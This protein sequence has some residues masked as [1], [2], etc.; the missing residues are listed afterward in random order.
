MSRKRLSLLLSALF[1]IVLITGYFLFYTKKDN[2]VDIFQAI[3]VD[4]SLIIETGNLKGLISALHEE[5]LIWKEL[6][7]IK[8]FKQFDNQLVFIDSLDR[9][10]K[11]AANIFRNNK[12]IISVHM[13]GRDGIDF[14]VLFNLPDRVKGKEVAETISEIYH[15]CTDT[16]KKYG[17]TEIHELKPNGFNKSNSIYYAV[18]NNIFILSYSDI[19]LESAIRQ[20]D[21][22]E[23]IK[24]SNGFRIVEKTAGHNVDA[25]L[26]IQFRTFPRLVSQLFGGEYQN[27][28]SQLTHLAN[29][30]ELDV[31]IKEEEILL[32]GFTYSNDSANNYLNIFSGQSAVNFEMD[33]V[34]PASTSVFIVYGINDPQLFRKKYRNYLEREGLITAY[35]NTL[36]EIKNKAGYE[37]EEEFYAFLGKE[38]GFAMTDIKNVDKS[39]N[40]IVVIK[41]RS[42]SLAEESLKKFISGYCKRTNQSYSNFVSYCKIDD[43]TKVPVYNSPVHFIPEKLFGKIFGGSAF[44]YFTFVDN[45]LVFGN[46][47]QSL[48]KIIHNNILQKTLHSDL[49]Y[50]E[51]ADELSDRYNFYFYINIPRGHSQIAN[52][53]AKEVQEGWK[54]ESKIVNKLHAFAIQFSESNSMLYNNVFLKYQPV[55]REEAQ[56]VWQSLLDTSFTFKP[57]LLENHYT[58]NKEVFVQDHSN[59]IY[60]INSAG[61]VLWKL[62]LEG[63]I[64]GQVYQIDLYKNGKLQIIFNTREKLYLID[65]NGNHVERFPVR[66]R[67][68]ATYGMSL[69]DYGNNRDYRIF[70]P[71]ED[72]KIYVYNKEGNIVSGWSFGHTET[73]IDS[74]IHHFRIGN[75]DY[76]VAADDNR[77]YILDRKGNTRVKMME[78]IAVSENNDIILDIRSADADPRMVTTDKS[79]TV[80][81]VYFNGKIEKEKIKDFS[82]EHFFN[83]MDINGDGFFEYI[84][85]DNK[86]LEVYSYSKSLL[87]SYSFDD[88]IE[89]RPIVYTFSSTN[90]KIGVVSEQTNKIYLFNND[91][92]LYKGFPVSGNTL[93]SIGRFKRNDRKYNLIVGSKDNFL[94][95]YSV[96]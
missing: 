53:L 39:Q 37:L 56:T 63:K 60:L 14:L 28:A 15:D 20:I 9:E 72:K 83:Y 67:F 87:F 7:E 38:V 95:N 86:K 13:I 4:A 16:A 79:G 69:F 32:N 18:K 3:P 19:L 55:Y 22:P 73:T 46:S 17:N 57:Q 45:Y 27:T 89:C 6:T 1:I 75:K 66:L 24:Q 82:P 31:N 49:H 11:L 92:K 51:F 52:Y 84:Y 96:K 80:C 5:N 88:I 43:E 12:I 35:Q 25:N 54:S 91:G 48:S 8:K 21:Q 26:Y 41:T 85:I 23:S 68:K 93:Y 90:K 61:R 94:Y 42:K 64:I 65:R 74:Y 81:F 59:K 58:N 62:H 47:F 10:V 77:I 29:W 44:P 40:S 30:A 2:K 78:N 76:I 36:N 50:R 71:G 70:I 33:K 34:L